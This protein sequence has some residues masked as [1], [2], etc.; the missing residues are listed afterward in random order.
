M[1]AA[2]IRDLDRRG[3]VIG[4]HSASHPARFSACGFD[5]MV[6]EWSQSRQRLEDLL[7]HAVAV[8]SVPGGYFSLAVAQ[9]AAY[10]GI[11]VLFTSEPVTRVQD[12]PGCL[13]MGRFTI[14]HG[15]RDNA[16]Q[17]L[18]LPSSRARAR[19]WMAWNAKGLVKP[20]LGPAYMRISDWLHATRLLKDPPAP[21]E[22]AAV[23]RDSWVRS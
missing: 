20:V 7:G 10:A 16:A 3:H 13:L 1:S 6:R 14:R 5:R 9:A 15:D 4:S 12:G 23:R 8:A 18:A 17:R 22:P 2:Q 11:R 19:A 21:A